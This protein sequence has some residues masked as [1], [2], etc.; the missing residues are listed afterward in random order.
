MNL[1]QG[2]ERWIFSDY[3]T[4]KKLIGKVELLELVKEGLTFILEDM[5]KERQIVYGTQHW[6]CKIISSGSYYPINTIGVFKI[7][8]V[9]N[10][11]PITSREQI[12]EDDELTEEQYLETQ[13]IIDKFVETDGEQ[14]Y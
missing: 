4:E 2:Q 5:P 1:E 13:L 11:G 7:R 14:W 10:I 12:D 6:K 3:Q 8:Y 9:N